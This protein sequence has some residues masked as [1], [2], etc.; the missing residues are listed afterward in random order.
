MGKWKLRS[1]REEQEQE[2]EWLPL[3]ALGAL[4]GGLFL[5]YIAA[6][7]VFYTRP[8]PLHWFVAASGAALGYLGGLFYHRWKTT[9]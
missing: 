7:A 5:A 4:T 6:E 8:H 3:S 9:S 1:P 2:D